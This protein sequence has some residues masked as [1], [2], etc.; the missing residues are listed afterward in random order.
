[1]LLFPRE[2]AAGRQPWARGSRV[3]PPCWSQPGSNPGRLA[4]EFRG[5][6]RS[7][8]WMISPRAW[9]TCARRFCGTAIQ[10]KR[11][12]DPAWKLQG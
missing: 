4:Q 9:M 10:I 3:A 1:V 5:P 2:T 12:S 11:R 7:A 8:M 6:I